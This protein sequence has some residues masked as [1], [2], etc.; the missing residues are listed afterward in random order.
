M[1]ETDAYGNPTV[2]VTSSTVAQEWGEAVRDRVVTTYPTTAARDTEETSPVTGRLCYVSGT[3]TLY[4]YDGATWIAL[5]SVA[6]PPVVVDAFTAIPAA[7]LSSSYQ[8]LAGWSVPMPSGW[9]ECSVLAFGSIEYGSMPDEGQLRCYME[10]DGDDGT[11]V[12]SS[13]AKNPGG[14]DEAHPTASVSV[15]HTVEAVTSDPITIEIWGKLENAST[16]AEAGKYSNS[17]VVLVRSG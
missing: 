1:A 12:Q 6:V 2:P 11:S 3:S 7:P 9:A 14:G 16:D 8:E 17:A 5:S 15:S 13:N 4:L 10:I